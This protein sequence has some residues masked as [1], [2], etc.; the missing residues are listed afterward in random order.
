VGIKLLL[1]TSFLLPFFGLDLGDINDIVEKLYYKLSNLY[2]AEI[3]IYEAKFKLISLYRKKRIPIDLIENFWE[4]LRILYDDDRII[5][6]PYDKE[7]DAN[8][9]HL[10][11]TLE[12]RLGIVDELIIASA[13]LVGNLLTLDE[14]ILRMRNVMAEKFGLQIFGLTD[15]SELVRM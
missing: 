12:E 3:S 11:K 4:N 10:E 1:D 2:F 7:V 15:I 13:M 5:F 8:L 9:N 14:D 6:I